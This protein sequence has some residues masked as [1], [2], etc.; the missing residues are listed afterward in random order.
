M[1]GTLAALA[2]RLT[3]VAQALARLRHLVEP[4]PHIETA[5]AHGARLVREAQ[6]SQAALRAA[7]APAY[8]AMGMTGELAGPARRR[9]MMAEGGRRAEDTLCSH[10]MGTRREEETHAGF[11]VRRQRLGQALCTRRRRRCGGRPVGPGR[12]WE[13]AVPDARSQTRRCRRS[14]SMAGLPQPWKGA[15]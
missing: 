1:A 2:R 7:V 14:M 3:H 12:V 6:A 9:A 8:E 11:P 4:C 13:A 5:A 10:E 15:V